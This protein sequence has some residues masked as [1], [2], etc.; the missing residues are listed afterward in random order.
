[1]AETRDE[2]LDTLAGKKVTEVKKNDTSITLTFE[3][4]SVFV[5]NA[6]SG[7]GA[8]SNWHN[9]TEVLLN[10]LRVLDI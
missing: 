5:V 7:P 6:R 8:D 2:I 1:M 4:G 3:D 10:G 9:W